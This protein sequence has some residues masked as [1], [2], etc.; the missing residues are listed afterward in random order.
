[1]I[2][3]A[4]AAEQTRGRPHICRSKASDNFMTDYRFDA[5]TS[6]M[7]LNYAHD[8]PTWRAFSAAAQRHLPA[9]EFISC[10]KPAFSHSM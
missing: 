10:S 3:R 8:V 1:M 9:E 7:V 5:A 6:V 2:K 4:R